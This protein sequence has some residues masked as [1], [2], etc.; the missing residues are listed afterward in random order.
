[1]EGTRVEFTGHLMKPGEYA[2][3]AEGYFYACT[4]SGMLANLRSHR[5]TEHPDGTITVEPS[6][7]VTGGEGQSW[8]G[9]LRAGVWSEC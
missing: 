2:K 3:H 6:I 5:V 4:P 1:M 9:F 7:L 8:H